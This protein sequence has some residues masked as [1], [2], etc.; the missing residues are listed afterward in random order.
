MSSL[1]KN[2]EKNGIIF[3]IL[4]SAQPVTNFINH[5]I[6]DQSFSSYRSFFY[7]FIVLIIFFIFGL[8]LN[9]LTRRKKTIFIFYLISIILFYTFNYASIYLSSKTIWENIFQTEVWRKHVFLAL[10]PI[11]IF[12]IYISSFFINFIKFRI[13]FYSVFLTFI[14]S[15][16]VMLMPHYYAFMQSSKYINFE[17]P[18]KAKKID[19][20]NAKGPNVYFIIPDAMPALHRVQE[21]FFQ[22]YEYETISEFNDLGFKFVENSE[23][24]GIDTYYTVPHFFT[25]DYFFSKSGKI[26]E[27][28]H[29][30]LKNVF[31]GY[32]PLIAEFRKRNYKYIRVDGAYGINPCSGIEDICIS[33]NIMTNNQDRVFLERTYLPLVFLILERNSFTK[34]ILRKFKL[35]YDNWS[36]HT[37][38]EDVV[39]GFE[40][41]EKK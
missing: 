8:I 31:R 40:K 2:I 5:N 19:H 39:F 3:L 23:A 26:D 1:L 32:N 20:L 16:I 30:E 14:I 13:I 10:I 17:M 37:E 7:F 33:P 27:R 38:S 36:F 34:R 6:N 12:T 15:D 24:N 4:C 11:T 28:L 41:L 21:T 22:D 25:M 35:S 9:L 18:K 29:I